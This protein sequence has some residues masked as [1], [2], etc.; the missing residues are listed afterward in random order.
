[1]R[2]DQQKDGVVAANE[3]EKCEHPV[4]LLQSGTGLVK[5]GPWFMPMRKSTMN[6]QAGNAQWLKAGLQVVRAGTHIQL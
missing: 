1:M 4:L 6:R 5:E 3:K 2:G